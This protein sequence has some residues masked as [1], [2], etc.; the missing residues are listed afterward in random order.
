MLNYC[1]REQCDIY[2][3]VV[4]SEC[5]NYEQINSQVVAHQ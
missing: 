2:S 5:I 3:R 4:T 1:H